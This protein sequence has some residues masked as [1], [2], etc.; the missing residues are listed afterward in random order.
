VSR[1]PRR[2]V[3][4]DWG[5]WQAVLKHTRQSSKPSTVAVL[6]AMENVCFEQREKYG[7]NAFAGSYPF[8]ASMSGVHEDTVRNVVELLEAIGVIRVTRN[9]DV[10]RKQYSEN[11]YT[12]L[13]IGGGGGGGTFRGG[14]MESEGTAESV[15]LS[16]EKGEA[17]KCPAADAASPLALRH[18]NASH[19]K[20]RTE[21]LAAKREAA[22]KYK[23]EQAAA[24]EERKRQQE[25]ELAERKERER[26]EKE[27]RLERWRVAEEKRK[28]DQEAAKLAEDARR[29]AMRTD[30]ASCVAAIHG[31]A[32]DEY[33]PGTLGGV[34]SDYDH[35][36]FEEAVGKLR[37]DMSNKVRACMKNNEWLFV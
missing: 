10:R 1:R 6:V 5:R 16:K 3:M 37:E 31:A 7:G 23:A 25:A 13:L 18:F 15:A 36:T 21:A 17:L 2:K 12:L 26:L 24:A 22:A 27:E 20:D 32:F 29:L 28:A 30:V 8:L 33:D 19:S 34:W 4:L 11:Y 35:N 14:V 9:Y